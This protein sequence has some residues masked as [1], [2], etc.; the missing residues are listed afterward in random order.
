MLEQI[1]GKTGRYQKLQAGKIQKLKNF[2][3]KVNVV[4]TKT[5]LIAS[6]ALPLYLS[7]ALSFPQLLSI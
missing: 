4:D 7:F 2:G 3:A 5:G 6:P 1:R